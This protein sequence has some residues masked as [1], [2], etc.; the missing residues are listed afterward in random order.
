MKDM[1]AYVPLGVI[2]T[3]NLHGAHATISYNKR[4]GPLALDYEEKDGNT[5]RQ[6]GS[7]WSVR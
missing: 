5:P 6:R 7:L 3:A 2:G 1:I 4:L